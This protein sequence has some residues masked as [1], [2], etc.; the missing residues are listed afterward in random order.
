MATRKAPRFAVWRHGAPI[1]WRPNWRLPKNSLAHSVLIRFTRGHF[2]NVKSPVFCLSFGFDSR[3]FSFLSLFVKGNLLPHNTKHLSFCSSLSV[4]RSQPNPLH[5]K[6]TLRTKK[7]MVSTWSL[8]CVANLATIDT[9]AKNFLIF[10]VFW[11]KAMLGVATSSPFTL[12][13]IALTRMHKVYTRT[14]HTLLFFHT[15]LHVI[16]VEH[17]LYEVLPPFHNTCGFDFS[18]YI[19]TAMYL[20]I[21]I[22]LE[23]VKMTSIMKRGKYVVPRKKKRR[24]T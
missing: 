3:A 10:Y 14:L 7:C 15:A 2:Q 17:W 19:P 6:Q 12:E 5:N 11:L 22:Y 20:D 24:G 21:R 18:R 13:M 16:A 9:C 23:E 1:T 4:S 8:H